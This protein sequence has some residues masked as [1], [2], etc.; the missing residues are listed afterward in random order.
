MHYI[1]KIR[2]TD[3]EIE[4]KLEEDELAWKQKSSHSQLSLRL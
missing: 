3:F 2:R 1:D 4:I